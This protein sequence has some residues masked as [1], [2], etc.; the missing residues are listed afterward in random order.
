MGPA[1]L[2]NYTIQSDVQGQIKDNKMPDVGLI[3]QGYTLELQG[4][5]QKLQIRT[6]ATVL[7]MA[8]TIDFAWEPEVWYTIKLTTQADG[9]TLRVLGKVWPRDA[10]EP[11]DWTIEAV[12]PS[13][14]RQGSPGLFGSAKDAE[15]YL[16]NIH[17][18]PN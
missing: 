13:P 2:S 11:A 7:R 10:D 9:D 1:D 18:T 16:D 12:D 17:V 8:E 6:W 3:N 15:I 14:Q 5:S 4:A